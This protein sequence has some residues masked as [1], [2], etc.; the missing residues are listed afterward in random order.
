MNKNVYFAYT[1]LHCFAVWLCQ[2]ASPDRFA[3]GFALAIYAKLAKQ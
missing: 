1:F 2:T 3:V